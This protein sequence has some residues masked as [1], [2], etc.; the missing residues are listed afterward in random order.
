MNICII[1]ICIS[2]IMINISIIK[3]EKRLSNLELYISIKEDEEIIRRY[4]ERNK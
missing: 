1:L 2:V 4:I 3:L